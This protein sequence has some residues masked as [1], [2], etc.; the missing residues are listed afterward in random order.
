MSD[1][2]TGLRQG[3][4]PLGGGDA[5]KNGQMKNTE[6]QYLFSH[7]RDQFPNKP[8]HEDGNPDMYTKENIQ[9]R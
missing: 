6:I 4:D 8:Y 3:D 9:K 5:D 1:D 7:E 2:P